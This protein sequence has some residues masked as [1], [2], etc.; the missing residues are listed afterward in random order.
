M[1]GKGRGEG[2]RREGNGGEYQ[3]SLI[4][5]GDFGLYIMFT[6]YTGNIRCDVQGN[7]VLIRDVLF[8]GLVT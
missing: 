2:R 4:G 8:L 5:I 3:E 7:T 1:E 6:N